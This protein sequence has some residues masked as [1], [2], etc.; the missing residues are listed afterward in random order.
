MALDGESLIEADE[1][2]PQVGARPALE[3]CLPPG[4]AIVGFNCD[5]VP[6]GATDLGSGVHVMHG[7]TGELIELHS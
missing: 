7:V 6:A 3:G 2:P 1:M 4:I 5:V